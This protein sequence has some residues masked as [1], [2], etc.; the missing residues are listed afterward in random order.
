MF[1]QRCVSVCGIFV[2]DLVLQYFLLFFR[3]LQESG[4]YINQF[5]SE[6]V[7]TC[8]DL[9]ARVCQLAMPSPD[10]GADLVT[11]GPRWLPVTFYLNGELPQFV[12]HYLK[13]KEK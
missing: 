1:V 5:P 7:L 9:L 3:S 2:N 11:R 13:R 10:G 8:K 4:K 6:N 12:Q